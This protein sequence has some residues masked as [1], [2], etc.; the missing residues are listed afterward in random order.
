MDLKCIF[1]IVGFVLQQDGVVEGG[2]G[3][4]EESGI[5]SKFM[6]YMSSEAAE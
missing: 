3:T 1:R 2:T 4:L 6:S 5:N